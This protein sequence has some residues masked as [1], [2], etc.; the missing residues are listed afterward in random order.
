MTRLINRGKGTSLAVGLIPATA[1]F[2]LWLTLIIPGP[3][4][5]QN[6]IKAYVSIL[7]QAYFVERIAGDEAEITVLVG[8]GQS[9][10]TY[11]PSPNEMARLSDADVYFKIGVPFETRLLEKAAKLLPDLN[12]VDTR[13]GLTL[14]HM[15]SDDPHHDHDHHH[16]DTDPHIWLDP[17]L[18]KIQ[19]ATITDEL[20]RLA[21]EHSE[22]FES[23]LARFKT[24]LDSLD[25]YIGTLLEPYSRRSI[26]VF[27]PSYGYF[28]DRYG[29]KQ[30]AIE[31]GG[32]EPGARQL[33]N[34]IENAETDDFRAI[35]IQEQF[36]QKT[37]RAL[38]RELNLD[39]IAIDPLARDYLN[40]LG[41]MAEKIASALGG[42]GHKQGPTDE[43]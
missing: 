43:K 22:L 27:H 10:A 3:A 13:N 41:Q 23:N 17:Q 9:P 19:A 24:E 26:L 21:P 38:A 4:F 31:S 37:A 25:N 1:L 12:M 20:I 30:V 42:S 8:P 6:T 29:L 11:S 36:S 14:R 28:T 40:N 7:P 15:E 16:G 18:V 34:L 35:F 39:I 33:S 2:C 32:K 5:G